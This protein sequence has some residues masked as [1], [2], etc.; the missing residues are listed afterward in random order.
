[1]LGGGTRFHHG[2]RDAGPFQPVIVFGLAQPPA[3]LERLLDEIETLIDAVAAE[4]DVGWVLPD[5]LDSVGLPY[6]VDAPD[7]ERV[8]R[9]Q[10]G[11][12]VDGAF[13]GEGGLRGAV[14]AEAAGRN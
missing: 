10:L 5:R 12:I 4:L 7:L 9:Q 8:H 6:L 14:A 11:E 2:D 3:A 1:M 13:D